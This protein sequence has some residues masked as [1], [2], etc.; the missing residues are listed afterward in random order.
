M[1]DVPTLYE[2]ACARSEAQEW[3]SVNAESQEEFAL[4]VG[5]FEAGFLAG[6]RSEDLRA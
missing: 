4:M 6:L 3:A 5:A 1:A 2:E